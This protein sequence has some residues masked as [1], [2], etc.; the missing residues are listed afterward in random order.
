MR[1]TLAVVL[2]ST[3]GLVSC[4]GTKT[5]TPEPVY[6]TVAGTWSGTI[7]TG[8]VGTVNAQITLAQSQNLLTGTWTS[9]ADWIGTLAGTIDTNGSFSGSLTISTPNANGTRC[10]GSGSFGGA[11]TT[12]RFSAASNGFNGDCASLPTNV[13]LLTQRQ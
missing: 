1:K 5:T 8:N 9:P 13:T 10:T 12:S 4:G 7:Q 3:F 2:I 11:F 6:P